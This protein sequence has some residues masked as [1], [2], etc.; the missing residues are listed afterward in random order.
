MVLIDGGAHSDARGEQGPY[1]FSTIPLLKNE[2]AALAEKLRAD[3]VESAT[4]IY[5]SDDGGEAAHENIGTAF[6]GEGGQMILVEQ[7]IEKVL[8]VARRVVVINRGVVQLDTLVADVTA[9][10]IWR[11]L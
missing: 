2:S 1:L 11:L 6:E 9:D 4:I 10:D 5:T 3:G 7:N 8:Q